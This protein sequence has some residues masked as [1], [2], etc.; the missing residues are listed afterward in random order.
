ML[1][2]SET[3]E[4]YIL[5]QTN[6]NAMRNLIREEINK[7]KGQILLA[8][9]VRLAFH[10]CMGM[11]C[12]GCIQLSNKANAGVYIWYLRYSPNV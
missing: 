1:T 11:V 6:V 7:N 12:D 2:N 4:E 10:D 3:A 8:G 9:A 5:T